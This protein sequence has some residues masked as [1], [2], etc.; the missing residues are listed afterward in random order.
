[1]R[2]DPFLT[3]NCDTCG[4]ALLLETLDV[5]MQYALIALQKLLLFLNLRA[6]KEQWL[7]TY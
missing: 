5:F 4:M 7:R 2:W 1:M 6:I 3:H